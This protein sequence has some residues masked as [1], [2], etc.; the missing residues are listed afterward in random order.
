METDYLA[1]VH[2]SFGV[3]DDDKAIFEG[4]IHKPSNEPMAILQDLRILIDKYGLAYGLLAL[5]RQQVNCGFVL[6]D[7]LN[8]EAKEIR[9]FSDQ[10]SG[11]EFCLMW[12]PDREL[13]RNHSL[14][15]RRGVV[16]EH[17]DVSKLI[18]KSGDGKPCHLCQENIALQNPA[19]VLLS[20]QLAGEQYY[21]GANFAYITNNH[22]TIMSSEHRPQRYSRRVLVALSDFVEQTDGR[23]RAIFNGLAGASIPWHEHMQVTTEKFPIEDILMEDA[24]VVHRKG[25]VRVSQPFYYVPV[26]IVEG[27]AANRVQD[28]VHRIV[29]EWHSLDSIHHTENIISTKKDNQFSTFLILRD[30][31]RLAGAGKVGAMA[32]FECGGRIVLSYVPDPDRPS[33]TNERD[34]F[35]SATLDKVRALLTEVTP[36]QELHQVDFQ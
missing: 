33:Q 4:I 36:E 13:R 16:A 27:A 10:K 3:S 29:E 14:L 23:F 9:R 19:E 6:A 31:R 2:A 25:D 28:A 26:W 21:A 12:N 7:P 34:T 8:P 24:S 22:F 30:T 1:E 32:S 35:K 15:I 5:Y 20:I 18:N 11:V 17:V